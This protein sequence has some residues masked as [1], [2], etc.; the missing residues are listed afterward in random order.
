MTENGS[1]LH[2]RILFLQRYKEV[3]IS[4]NR[5]LIDLFGGGRLVGKM[6]YFQPLEDF[7]KAHSHSYVTEKRHK[8]GR[9][10]AILAQYDTRR[11]SEAFQRITMQN[12][13]A[14]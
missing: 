2:N 5:Q 11:T 14:K 10:E 13:N 9:K 6:N 7:S 1:V 8:V 3:F 4:Q 12:N